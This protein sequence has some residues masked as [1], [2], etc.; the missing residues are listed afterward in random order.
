MKLETIQAALPDSGLRQG[1]NWLFSPKPLELDKRT[2]KSLTRLGHPLAQFQ[3]ASDSVYQRSAKGKLPPWISELLDAG[4]PEWITSAQRSP[5]LRNTLPRVIRPDLILTGDE[6]HSSFALT[7]LDSVPG[8]M[9]ITLWLSQFY[10][11]HGYDVLGGEMGIR[12]GFQS[13][14]PDTGG[15]VL[16]S[17]ESADYLPE[18]EWLASQCQNLNTQ[19]AEQD[20]GEH[21][22]AYRFFEWF[23][24]QNIP[25]AQQLAAS[26]KLS[27]PCKPHL[28]EKL[29]LALLHTPSLRKIWQQELRANHLQRLLEIIPQGWV[30]DPSPLP[31]HASLPGL[32]VHSWEDVANFSQK[33]RQL[34]LK[35]SG[36]SEL[37]WGS[38][39]VHIGHDMPSNEWQEQVRQATASIHQQ[40][41]MMQRYHAGKIIEHPYFDPETGQERIMQGRARLCPYFFTDLAGKTTFAGCLATIVPADKKKIHGMK[42]GILVPCMV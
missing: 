7:E 14:F 36:F 20:K 37:A 15:R 6:T 26:P 27:S 5:E 9:G 1:A 3:R 40:P 32:N 21:S 19:S 2:A 33:E 8:G 11:Q 13:L 41:W 25:A 23:D 29:W 24:W 12:E 31:P 38:R 34:V 42:D 17:E 30:V 28:E 10:S 35:V 22:A 4:K 18:M 16:V 39:G